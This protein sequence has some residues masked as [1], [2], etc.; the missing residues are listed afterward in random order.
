MDNIDF[1]VYSKI[2]KYAF[3]SRREDISEY[4]HIVAASCSIFHS[5][6]SNIQVEFV[7]R[8]AK[9]VAHTLAGEATLLASPA[10]YYVIPSCIESLIINEML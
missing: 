1:E 2:T 6:F 10:I 4:G 9:V 5:K 8:Q 3:T 7:R